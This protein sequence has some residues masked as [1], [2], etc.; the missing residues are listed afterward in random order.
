MHDISVVIATAALADHAATTLSSG[1]QPYADR[2]WLL[3]NVLLPCYV[4]W[5][6]QRFRE[7]IVVGEYEEGEGYTYVPFKSVYRNC[8]DALLKRQAGF[9]ALTKQTSWVL[10]QHDDHIWDPRNNVDP[11]ESAYVLSPSRFTRARGAEEPLNDGFNMAFD[12]R[13]GHVN[14]HVCLMKPHV[15]REGFKWTDAPPVF[16]WDKSVT[17]LLRDRYPIRYAPE[18]VTYDLERGAEPWK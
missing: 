11:R 4:N 3:R 13:Y 15:F 12:P 2:A 10:F 5:F 7:I 14:G 18:L 16:T 6:P 17:E 1:Y 9:D 8:A